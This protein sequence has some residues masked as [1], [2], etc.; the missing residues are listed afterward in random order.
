MLGLDYKACIGPQILQLCHSKVGACIVYLITQVCF[1]LVKQ[2]TPNCTPDYFSVFNV[3]V[4]FSVSAFSIASF[5]IY[6]DS[7][8]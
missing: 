2:V 1:G 3:C 8:L 6:L 5:K 7:Q 4:L